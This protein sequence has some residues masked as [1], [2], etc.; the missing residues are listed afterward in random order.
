MTHPDRE[1]LANRIERV[2][3]IFSG[4]IEAETKDG[5]YFSLAKALTDDERKAIVSALRDS[6]SR[7]LSQHMPTS[8]PDV[9]EAL[10]QACEYF[11]NL[12]DVV[13]G[14]YGEPSPNKEMQLA[15]LCR[16]AL[17]KL[18]TPRET[19]AG[20][21]D[22]DAVSGTADDQ[23][24]FAIQE[25]GASAGPSTLA[26]TAL[27]TDAASRRGEPEQAVMDAIERGEF[28]DLPLIGD[29]KRPSEPNVRRG[30]NTNNEALADRWSCDERN[31]SGCRNPHG[32][33]CREITSLI[34]ERDALGADLE[35]VQTELDAA[36]RSTP[37]PAPVSRCKVTSNPVGTDTWAEGYECK[38]APCQIML[39]GTPSPAVERETWPAPYKTPFK[40]YGSSI[41]DADGKYVC[42]F[43][44]PYGLETR[45]KMVSLVTDAMNTALS[46]PATAK[47]EA[48]FSIQHGA[49]YLFDQLTKLDAPIT[50]T[51]CKAI[52]TKLYAHPPA[53]PPTL[54]S[55]IS[56]WIDGKPAAVVSVPDRADG[57]TIDSEIAECAAAL[58]TIADH[59]DPANSTQW[60]NERFYQ[61]MLRG[62]RF[63]KKYAN[64]FQS[65]VQAALFEPPESDA[66]DNLEGALID[67]KRYREA[68]EPADAVCVRTIERV[69]AQIEKVRD[70]LVQSPVPTEQ[71]SK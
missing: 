19:V 1:A 48:V 51:A 12:E 70:A 55:K 41:R 34:V 6:L 32:C 45:E 42:E 49:D 8:N 14:D 27:T 58:A 25:S 56:E 30:V 57:P 15:Q 53:Q 18:P 2:S 65:A 63:A 59:R 43:S 23:G 24:L 62:L 29:S 39:L 67:I 54:E 13:D 36:L 61:G 7:P 9:A 68:G 21:T 10:T 5:G 17:E 50:Y 52:I 31:R 64:G 16:D 60:G 44:S 71:E 46:Q 40:W 22:I 26:V 4:E 66:S 69:Q 11:E 3:K 37:S 35:K 33:H 20:E 47:A 38:C 28:T